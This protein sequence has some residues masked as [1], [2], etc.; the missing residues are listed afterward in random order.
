VLVSNLTGLAWN[1][2][3][4]FISHRDMIKGEGKGRGKE[5]SATVMGNSKEDEDVR[6]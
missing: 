4:S 2:Y 6:A 3:F 5:D 1:S